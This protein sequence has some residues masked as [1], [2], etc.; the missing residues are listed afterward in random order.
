VLYQ[1]ELRPAPSKCTHGVTVRAD[2][3]AL[4]D[5]LK[6]AA[7]VVP[8]NQVGELCGFRLSGQMVPLHRYGRKH[9]PAVSAWLASLEGRVPGPVTRIEYPL[10]RQSPLSVELVV[11]A[12]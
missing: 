1:A 2:Q 11:T 10:L 4:L 6:N 8:A 12:S 7:F 5:L 9:T 3:F